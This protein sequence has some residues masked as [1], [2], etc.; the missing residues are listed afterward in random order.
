MLQARAGVVSAFKGLRGGCL[1]FISSS[2]HGISGMTLQAEKRK[3]NVSALETLTLELQV[4]SA[5]ISLLVRVLM[6]CLT[7][8]IVIQCVEE[9]A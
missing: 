4:C 3:R 6:R 1:G 5:A 9:S 7:A 8:C 2:V